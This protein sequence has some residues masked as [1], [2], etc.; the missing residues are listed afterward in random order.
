MIRVM[1]DMEKYTHFLL[2]FF[3]VCFSILKEDDAPTDLEPC[4]NCG[5]NFNV[6]SL[7]SPYYEPTFLFIL[8]FAH[9]L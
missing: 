4:S 8:G 5:R 1:N 9:C 6:E 3:F 2:F 7:V